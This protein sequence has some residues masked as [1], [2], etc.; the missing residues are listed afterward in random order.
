MQHS[1]KI[2]RYWD[3]PDPVETIVVPDKKYFVMGDYRNNSADSRVWG[4][5]DE[6]NIMGKVSTVA[7]SVSRQRLG[8][9]RF[10]LSIQ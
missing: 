9:S 5:V 3:F 8:L 2:N 4:F 6:E 10:A 7:I 1:F